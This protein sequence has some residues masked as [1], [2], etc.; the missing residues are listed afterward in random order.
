MPE[1]PS[2]K[3]T[4]PDQARWSVRPE[5][6]T[7]SSQGLALDLGYLSLDCM[8]LHSLYQSLPD[9][10]R[11]EKGRDSECKSVR[12]IDSYLPASDSNL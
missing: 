6:K 2:V 9:C 10:L 8:L 12:W 11:I 3:P 1:V 4:K 5:H 7:Q